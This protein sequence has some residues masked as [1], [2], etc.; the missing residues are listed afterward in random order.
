MAVR[1]G[2]IGCGGM[3]NAHFRSLSGMEN[4]ERAA[5]CDVNLDRAKQATEQYGG[6][7]HSD[8]REMLDKEKPDA[9][10]IVVPPGF[11]DDIE[12]EV[13]NRGIPFFIEKP[14][15]LTN[16]TTT[17]VQEAIDRNGVTTAVGYHWRYQG[18]T[19][20]AKEILKDKTVGMVL[21]YWMGSLPGVAW[22]RRMDQSGG[23]FV[24]QTT[25]IL[26]LARYLVGDVKRV[27]AA[28]GLR[29]MTDVDNIDVPDV[30]TATLEFENG[31]VGT[32]NNTCM[33]G[34]GGGPVSLHIVARDLWMEVGGKV[35]VRDRGGERVEGE[36]VNA[37]A[38]E[39]A[40]F[41]KAVETGDRT[42]IRSDYA[43]GA[44]TLA[45]SLAINHSFQ[46]R[47]PVDL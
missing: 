1:V 24:E 13:A 11:H 37:T 46:T 16:E 7:A 41:I 23:Q 30:G 39:D 42:D 35:K 36:D 47:Q 26:D 17:R 19:D 33:L 31:A 44:K 22:W 29:C 43:D 45:L 6:N 28:A 40:A 5:F 12:V 14:V 27:Y 8:F 2:F 10:Y 25:H 4:V 38:R 32:M 34:A 21:G 15:A 9:V 18:G 20:R 3:A